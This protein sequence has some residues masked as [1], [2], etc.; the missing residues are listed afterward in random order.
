MQAGPGTAGQQIV[1][2]RQ[3]GTLDVRAAVIYKLVRAPDEEG[4]QQAP[5]PESQIGQDIVRENMEGRDTGFPLGP[6]RLIGRHLQRESFLQ[7]D[8]IRPSD[9]LA[10]QS[11][12]GSGERKTVRPDKELKN[13]DHKVLQRIIRLGTGRIGILYRHQPDL[14]TSLLQ[15]LHRTL[16]GGRQT[17]AFVKGVVANK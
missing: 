16:K 2:N 11:P 13:G 6:C 1:P 5:F 4:S 9:R 12:V 15:P 10:D 8:D 17:V 7:M 14:Q 3:A